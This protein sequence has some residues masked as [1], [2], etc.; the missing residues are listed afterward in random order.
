MP[1]FPLPR[2]HALA[3]P[4]TAVAA[5]LR[6]WYGSLAATAASEEAE[7]YAFT[8]AL[9]REALPACDSLQALL[10]VYYVP[11]ADLRSFVA[12]LCAA[13]EPPL[14]PRVVM[15]A[16]CALRLRQLVAAV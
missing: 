8:V 16:A 13:G 15:G 1:Q 7:G 6:E 2:F 14:H 10:Q 12:E 11:D 3:L 4:R 5:T 9:I